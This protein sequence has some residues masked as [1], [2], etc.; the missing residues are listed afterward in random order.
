MIIMDHTYDN[1]V[2]TVLITFWLIAALSNWLG[3]SP[4]ML[5]P[6]FYMFSYHLYYNE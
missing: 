1:T 3:V 2:S 4:K 6:I 5:S